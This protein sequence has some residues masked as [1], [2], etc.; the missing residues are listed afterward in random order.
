MLLRAATLEGI[1][2]GAVT[3]VYR[4]WERA[5]VRAGTRLRTAIGVVSVLA[6]DV[7]SSVPES[8]AALAGYPSSAALLADV[9]GAAGRPLF[10]IAVAYGG[11]DPRIALRV[12]VDS[13][14]PV[15]A[16]VAR[17]P[18]A[19]AVLRLIASHPEVRAADL[20]PLGGYA[21]TLV[22]KRDVRKL[23]ELGL[24]ESLPVGY[25]ISPR[26]SAVLARLSGRR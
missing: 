1:R 12:D 22:F 17:M 20:A 2:T 11:E 18:W 4:R 23:K 3:L 25:R 7:V 5:R 6:V 13:L 10:R 26:G 8:D 24:T 19:P 9:P 15:V 14:D 16:R 21:E